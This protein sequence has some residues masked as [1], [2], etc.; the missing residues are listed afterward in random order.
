MCYPNNYNGYMQDLY[1]YNQNPNS[2]N[3]FNPYNNYNQYPQPPFNLNNYLPNIY[4]I[5]MPVIIKVLNNSNYQFLNEDVINNITDTVYNIVEGEVIEENRNQ[6]AQ[7]NQS[8]QT[9]QNTYQNKT[10]AKDQE[11]KR[12]NGLLKDVIKILLIKELQKRQMNFF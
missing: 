4:K 1:F 10:D 6:N 11:I 8:S 3:N 2:I 12:E 7:A 9:S 5:V